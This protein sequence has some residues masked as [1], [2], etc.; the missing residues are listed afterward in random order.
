MQAGP[1]FNAWLMPSQSLDAAQLSI[2]PFVALHIGRA[3]GDVA[4]TVNI[5][6]TLAG[7]RAP[8]SGRCTARR[9]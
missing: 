9:W 7:R 8:A 5:D 2:E 6:E 3:F 1:R 4:V